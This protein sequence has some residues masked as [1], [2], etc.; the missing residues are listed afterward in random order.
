MAYR[1]ASL[2][3]RVLQ[4]AFAS[5]GYK[6]VRLKGY[7]AREPRT[8]RSPEGFAK[9]FCIGFNKT[10]TTTL[11]QVLRAAGLRSPKQLEQEALLVGALDTGDF[12]RLRSFCEE[13]DAFQD[14]PFSQGSTYVACDALFPGSRF[15]LTVRDPQAWADSYIRYYR[16][17]FGLENVDRFDEQ[18]FADKALYL[19]AGYVH[20]ILR[21]LLTETHG[22]EPT[23]RWDLAF[24][25][26]FLMDR[27]QRRNAE[28]RA[29]FARRPQDLL[30]LDPSQEADTGS[31]LAFL[32]RTDIE[33]S[34]YPRAN[35][36]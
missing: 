2:P 11:E 15:I 34:P 3:K 25:Q 5:V 31:L 13:Y 28:I 1:G 20:R 26:D 14:L 18:T 8:R 36:G 12:D 35:A 23:T 19:E 7:E 6:L 10:A 30:V 21:P 29:Y 24:D 4:G 16:R 27:Y 9:L 17:E 33:P 32:G 22:G